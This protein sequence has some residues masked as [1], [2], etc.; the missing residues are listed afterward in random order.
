MPTP[1]TKAPRTNVGVSNGVIANPPPPPKK[2][3]PSTQATT[4]AKPQPPTMPII[5]P[6]DQ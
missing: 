4:L 3:E 5:P 1:K 2:P 6:A